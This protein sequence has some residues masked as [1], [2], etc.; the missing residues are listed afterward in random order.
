M[1][2]PDQPAPGE[3]PQLATISSTEFRAHPTAVAEKSAAPRRTS[4][5]FYLSEGL[6]NRAR[7]AYR[8]TSFAERDT[9]WSEMLNKA[10][11]AE[12]ERREAA[13][14]GGETFAASKEPLSPGRPIGF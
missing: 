3:H 13:Y 12:V 1:S 9:S 6:R 7:A 4:V 8:S 2:N 5:T 11:I 10:L 14:N